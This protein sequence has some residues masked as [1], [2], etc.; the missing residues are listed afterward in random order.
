M[1]W[2]ASRYLERVCRC[3]TGRWY[4]A[5]VG[6]SSACSTKEVRPAALNDDRFVHN[7]HQLDL[8]RARMCQVRSTLTPNQ[9]TSQA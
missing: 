6:E 2:H 7:A 5:E 8:D 1:K 9:P 3:S 4:H